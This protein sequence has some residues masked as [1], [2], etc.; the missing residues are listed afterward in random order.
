MAPKKQKQYLIVRT[1]SAGVHVGVLKKRA[2]TDVTLTDARR[3]WRWSGA[4]T[5]NE[6]S[7]KGVSEEYSRISEPVPEI[8]LTQAIELLPCSPEA[9]AN[10]TRSRWG[11]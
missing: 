7:V 5:L 3:V 8:T 11:K 1:F 10:L 4:N 6:M 2:G 9:A